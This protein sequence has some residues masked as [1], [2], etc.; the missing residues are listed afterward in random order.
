[1]ENSHENIVQFNLGMEW[2]Y[3]ISNKIDEG[4]KAYM[5]G[6]YMH[7]FYSLK[8]IKFLIV[9]YLTPKDREYIFNMETEIAKNLNDKTKAIPIIE[10]Y[11]ITIKDFLSSLGFLNPIKQD[12]TKLFGQD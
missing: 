7:W 11:D 2:N 9:S 8:A 12:R 4:L 10:K 5:G 3:K 1:M 6:N